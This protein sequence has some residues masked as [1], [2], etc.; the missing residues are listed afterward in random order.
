MI[1]QAHVLE[2]L[3]A[4]QDPELGKS[5]VELG[6]VHDVTVEGGVVRFTLALTT[7]AC[8]L[9]ERMMDD[10][11]QVLVGQD[12]VEDV[13]ITLREMT[14]PSIAPMNSINDA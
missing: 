13:Q 3:K 7:L 5:I 4:V 9:R 8:P 14:T 11:R 6:M 12:G 1:D 2:A 10:A